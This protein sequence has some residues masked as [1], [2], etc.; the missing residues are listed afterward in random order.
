MTTHGEGLSDN[1]PVQRDSRLRPV[2]EPGAKFSC[3]NHEKPAFYN[4]ATGASGR[5]RADDSH[6]FGESLKHSDERS[7][8]EMSRCDSL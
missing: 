3:K 8:N 4:P 2:S 1:Y 7:D 5:D 6:G